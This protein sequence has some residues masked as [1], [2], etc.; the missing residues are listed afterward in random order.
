MDLAKEATSPNSFLCRLPILIEF[1]FRDLNGRLKVASMQ[2]PNENQDDDIIMPD[3]SGPDRSVGVDIV[4]GA[5][6]QPSR[7]RQMMPLVLDRPQAICRIISLAI[8]HFRNQKNRIA[9]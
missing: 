3:F 6:F 4:L 8:V 9:I 7:T 5:A 2:A 1:T